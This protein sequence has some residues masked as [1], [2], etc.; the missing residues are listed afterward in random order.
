VNHSSTTRIRRS[1]SVVEEANESLDLDLF[2][3]Q[4]AL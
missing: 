4:T 2:G 3:D 1:P